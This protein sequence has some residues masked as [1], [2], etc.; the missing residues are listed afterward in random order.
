MLTQAVTESTRWLKRIWSTEQFTRNVAVLVGGTALGQ[1][2]VVLVSPLLTRLYTPEDFGILAIYVALLSILGVVASL[3]YEVA[4]PLPKDDEIAANVLALAL[5]IVL[6]LSVVVGLG[7]WLGGDQLTRL[8]NTPALKAYLWLLPLSLLGV[9][10]YQVFNRWAM[11]TGAFTQIARTR[12]NQSIG[13]TVTQLGLG[14]VQAGSLGLILGDVIGRASG[15]GTLA[16]LAWWQHGAALRRASL[17][18]MWQVAVRYRRFPLFSSGGFLLNSFGLQLPLLLLA[19]FY[20]PQIVG[21]LALA[22]RVMGIP[23]GLITAAVSQVYVSEAARMM[24]TAPERLPRLLA[25]VVGGMFLITCPYVALVALIA[26]ALFPVVFGSEWAEAGVYVRILAVMFVCDGI[27]TPTGGTLGVLER[28]DLHL[29]REITRVG[30]LSGVVFL[31]G[32]MGLGPVASIALFSAA[33]SIIYLVYLGI[34][35]YAMWKRMQVWR[36]EG[37][38]PAF[39]HSAPT[40]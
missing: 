38:E 4:I 9:G 25:K 30:L 12:L 31:A 34:S 8:V 11:R 3:A 32:T 23:L 39:E 18:G 27:A 19:S 17:A 2:L 21:W 1:A 10:A 5:A 36:S 13:M 28:Q 22:Q 14:W 24:H 26:P 37:N 16:T 35:V 20:Q 29:L 40:P 15:T 6:A 33:G 7:V